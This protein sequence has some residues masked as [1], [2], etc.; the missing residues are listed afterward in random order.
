ML[1]KYWTINSILYGDEIELGRKSAGIKIISHH[2]QWE[3]NLH[4]KSDPF[5]TPKG[6]DIKNAWEI[7]RFHQGIS[8]GKAYLL[9]G[10]EKYT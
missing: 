3:N 1:I 2:Y 6:T 5:R 10:D 9:T 4:W 8:L 7:A